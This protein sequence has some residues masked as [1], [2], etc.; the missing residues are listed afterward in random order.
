MRGGG[1]G[2]GSDGGSDGGSGDGSDEC[3]SGRGSGRG[4]HGG[5]LRSC[6][7]CR[8][9][10]TTLFVSLRSGFAGVFAGYGSLVRQHF[11][12]ILLLIECCA[13]DGEGLGNLVFGGSSREG[14]SGSSGGGSRGGSGSGCSGGSGV[15]SGNGGFDSP[16]QG[17]GNIVFP[18][19]DFVVFRVFNNEFGGS[20]A[21]GFQD[22][23]SGVGGGNGS[24]D[25]PFQG[26]GNIRV[27]NNEWGCRGARGF[28]DD[29]SGDL[30]RRFDVRGFGVFDLWGDS[31]HRL[32]SNISFVGFNRSGGGTSGDGDGDGGDGG[33]VYTRRGDRGNMR[34]FRHAFNSNRVDNSSCHHLTDPHSGSDYYHSD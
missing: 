21:R 15:E 23:I 22:D 1:G 19:F 14:G 9:G 26:K 6:S 30:C 27:F 33:D 29:I 25:S 3:G 2:G 20:G 4:E 24:F 13:D 5:R 10:F 28:Q 31:S 11:C 16:L 34:V 18:V 7:L 8:A 17:K 32:K 12:D